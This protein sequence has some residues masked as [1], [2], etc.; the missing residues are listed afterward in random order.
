[1]ATKKTSN[2]LP[3]IFQTDTN[4]KFLSATLDQLVTE[5]NL[6]NIYGYIGRT[7][8]PT[9]KSKDSYVI[10]SSAERQKYQLEPSIVVRD[11]QNEITFFASYIDV[12]NKIDYYSG[13]ASNHNRMFDG[14]YYSFAPLISF[15]KFV[16]FSQYYWLANGPDP[17]DVNTGGVELTRTFDVVRNGNTSRYDFTT[18]GLVKNTLT[19]ARGGSYIFNVD[20]MGAGFWI[21]TEPGVDGLVNATPTISTRDVLGVINNGAEAGTVTFNVPQANA[22]DRYVLMATVANVEYALP[23]AYSDIQNHTVS[24]FVA[25]FPQY[26]G[27]TGQLSG[28]TII[29]VN[30]ELLTNYGEAAWTMPEYIDD[31]GNIVP[32]FDA[33]TIIPDAQRYGVWTIQF[34]DVD[35]DDPMIRLVYAQDVAL[36]EKVYIKSGLVNANKEFFKDYDGFLHVVPV[37]SSIQN[38]LYFQDGV[39][40]AIYGT[41][42]LVD[43]AGWDIDIEVD[44]LGKTT[45]TS[46][47]G[48]IF[49]S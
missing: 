7:F 27:L 17:V 21:Q 42:K 49:T 31:A 39:N 34:N 1:M 15:D 33:G 22:Q 32:G 38:T 5:P 48:I 16:N 6:R 13:L 9:Y 30:Q 47:N 11:E 23:I 43:I 25:A 26:A 37:I 29:F 28:K 4:N 20:Q 18:G 3:T 44:I 46:P 35:A 40:P 41:I 24:Q 14:E 36:N 10:E 12:L 45:Y 19:L 8:A 2:F